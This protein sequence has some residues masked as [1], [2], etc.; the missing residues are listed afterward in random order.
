[1]ELATLKSNHDGSNNMM[2]GFNT[3]IESLTRQVFEL[4]LDRWREAP[5]PLGRFETPETLSQRA[6]QSITAPGLGG[7]EALRRWVE[8]LEP[9]SFSADHQRYFA[10]IPHAPTEASMIFD[11]LVSASSIFGG[12]WFEASGAV[13][14]ENEALRWIA[15]LAGFPAEAGG[16][17]VQGGSVGT[18]SALHAARDAAF[19]RR[20]DRPVRWRLAA[21]PEAHASVA[22]AARILDVE[23]VQI[24]VDEGQQ[25]SGAA[26]RCTLEADADKSIFAVVASAGTTNLGI[27]DELDAIADLCQQHGRWLHVDGAYGLAALAAPGERDSFSGIERADS[28]IVDPHKWFFAPY[29]CCALIYRAPISARMA[30]NMSAAY[31]DP[32]HV[33]EE[34]NPLDFGIHQSRRAR[35]LPFWFSLAVNGTDAYAR[36]IETTLTVARQAA[37]E[38][39]SRI[40]LQ[41]IME[42]ELTVLVFRRIGWSESDYDS[43]SA[44]LLAS[45][46]A[47]VMP[48]VF[49]GEPVARIVVL[50]PLTT[51]QDIRCVL[52]EMR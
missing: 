44:R 26:L 9:A 5:W 46:A 31:M 14:A 27:I 28:F 41:L 19:R 47:F 22:Q 33:R 36:A 38:I 23:L 29:D 17:F 10:F 52:D 37:E 30:H 45:G 40:E 32:I 34:W 21:S 18:L 6:G 1:M 3:E 39:K 16:T 35:G 24:P 11:L 13:H 48:T 20:G 42:P 51:I 12:T 43:W 50:N 25:L 8:I 2:H 4:I 7:S 49:Q 15:E